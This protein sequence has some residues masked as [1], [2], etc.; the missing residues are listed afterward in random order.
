MGAYGAVEDLYS[1]GKHALVDDESGL[2]TLSLY[3]MATTSQRSLVPQ[4]DSFNRYYESDKYADDIIRG[5]LDVENE[6]FKQASPEQRQEIV[7]KTMQYLVVYMAALQ[8]MYQ[9]IADCNSPDSG[10]ILD[11]Q[12][13]WDR[14]AA[15]LI[16]SLEGPEDDGNEE[17]LSFYRLA[18]KR[19]EQFGTCSPEGRPS[20]NE[21]FNSLLYTGRAS[22]EGRACGEL[23]KAV[24]EIETLLRVPLIQGTL[25]YALA[26]EK[27]GEN[28]QDKGLG[29][30]FAFS[31]SVLPLVEDSNRESAEIIN[32]NMDFQF[33]RVPVHD[34]AR[35]VFGAFARAFG[36]M[37]VNCEDVGKAEG[38][39]ACS[40][41]TSPG[42][43]RDTNAGMIVGIIVGVFAVIGI[44]A[45]LVFD[46]RRKRKALEERPSF[47]HPK[48]EMNHTPDR[49]MGDTYTAG[50]IGDDDDEEYGE[51][52]SMAVLVEPS[53]GKTAPLDSS[54]DN[55][56][57]ID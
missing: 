8:E 18:F 24:R 40:G 38:N 54:P 57:S 35:A 30:G 12:E 5:A 39:D 47:I 11:A 45:L 25:R 26:N 14:G 13:A 4:F 33:E 52:T 1:H 31:R 50:E 16:G 3:Q 22:V 41:A 48:G 49:M 21:E 56:F 9:A 19:C 2:R 43:P 42:G 44:V 10:K 53:P 6:K 37:N 51:N 28:S 34:R 29:E 27:L 15:F 32:S 55:S 23:R 20:W 17:G 36:K 46:R 7:V